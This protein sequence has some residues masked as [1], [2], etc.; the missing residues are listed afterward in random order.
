MAFFVCFRSCVDQTGVL[1]VPCDFV[2]CARRENFL[3]VVFLFS[4]RKHFFFR[5]KGFLMKK[6]I[7]LILILGLIAWCT[8]AQPMTDLRNLSLVAPDGSVKALRLAEDRPVVFL[9]LGP[10]CP[11]SQKYIPTIK[12][13]HQLFS[14]KVDFIGIFPG[15]FTLG[16]V[17]SFVKEYGLVFDWYI[18]RDMSAIT[19][20]HATVTPEAFL[21][22]PDQQR[23]YAGSIDDWFYE[24]GKYRQQ[25]TESYLKDAIESVLSGTPVK[26]AETKAIGCV[27]QQ[28]QPPSTGHTHDH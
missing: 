2:K 11:I 17:S 16:E 4:L 7:G 21:F 18:D 19:A 20:L 8:T 14:G 1:W 26:M 22:T 13:L 23:R 3:L 6:C 25:A 9:V 27:I 28:S 5:L 15:Y 10:D 24:L 12:A